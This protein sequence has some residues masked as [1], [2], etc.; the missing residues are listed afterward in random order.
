MSCLTHISSK[1]QLQVCVSML[2]HTSTQDVS[3]LIPRYLADFRFPTLNPGMKAQFCCVAVLH[4]VEVACLQLCVRQGSN[5]MFAS[6]A[7]SARSL[8]SGPRS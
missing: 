6:A 8:V 4:S 3:Q 1:G 2:L 7:V 5:S